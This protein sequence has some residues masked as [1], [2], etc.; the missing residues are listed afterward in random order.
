MSVAIQISPN[1]NLYVKDPQE[2][3]TGRNILKYAVPLMLELGFEKFT[4]RKLAH[5][6]GA[7]E[8]SMYRY[9]ENKHKLLLYLLSWYWEWVKYSISLNVQ[10]IDD[11]QKKLEIAIRTI[12]ES[13]RRNP[14]VEYVDEDKLYALVVEESEKAYH[15]KYVDK[16]NK[17]GFFQTLKSLK[18]ELSRIILLVN[19]SYKFPNSLA[20]TIIEMA[21]S[22][23]FFSD[24][25]PYMTD[26]SNNNELDQQLFDYLK[27]LTDYALKSK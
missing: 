6:I 1:E 11:N 23:R 14:L 18:A 3:K 9:F 24:H 5:E 2:T 21:L 10:N 27:H 8:I 22:L 20:T 4:F 7:S 17:E 15:T 25:L 13:N 12:I 26:I 16:E 19:P